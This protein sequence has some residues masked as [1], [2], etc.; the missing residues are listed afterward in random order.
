METEDTQSDQEENFLL[1]GTLNIHKSDICTLSILPNGY[2]ASAGG[3]KLVQ[4]SNPETGELVTSLK[5]HTSTILC[6]AISANGSLITGSTDKYI[7]LKR[8]KLAFL[9]LF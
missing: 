2:L 7:N 1:K 6:S 4:I 5:G 9:L 3:D 8:F